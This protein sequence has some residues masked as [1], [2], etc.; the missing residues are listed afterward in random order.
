ML[1]IT[2]TPTKHHPLQPKGRAPIYTA[3]NAFSRIDVYRLSARPEKGMPD[4]GFGIIIDGGAAGTAMGD[5]SM[6]VRNYLAH[7]PEYQA[8]G[9]PYV[10][11]EHA[12]ILIIGSG[13]GREVLEGLYYGASSITAVEINPIINDIVTRRMS[14]YWGGLFEQPEVRLITEDGRSFVR[15]SN[16]KYD[17][18]ISVQT[19]TD[20]A[21]ASGALTM[22]ESYM[23]TIEA[24]EDYFDH[25]TP[26]GVLLITRPVFQIP[27]LFVTA[28]EVF[29]RRGLGNP[30]NH[31]FAFEG[32]VSSFG[33][34]KFL[35]AFLFKKSPFSEAEIREMKERLGVNRSHPST[36]DLSPEIYYSPFDDPQDSSQN[37]FRAQLTE[38]ATAPHY[39]EIC[40]ASS[41]LLSPATDDC[42]FFNQNVRLSSL[43]PWVFH[44]VLAAG[45]RGNVDSQPVAETMIVVLLF[46]AI[47]IAAVLILLPLERFSMQGLRM[48]GR[49][50]FL[51]YFAA[52]G[53]GFIMIEIVLLQRF[54]LFLGQPIYTFAVVLASLLIFTGAGSYAASLFREST[55][56]VLLGIHLTIL[57]AIGAALLLTPWVLYSTLGLSLP[58]RVAIAAAL[59][60]PLGVI[61]GMPFP[62]GL[63]IVASEASPLVPW[64][65]GVN[66]FFTVIGSI[67]AMILGMALGFTAVLMLAG[68]CYL[69]AL[70][71]ITAY[72]A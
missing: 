71:A 52:V 51:T 14:Q 10:G 55:R 44:N 61:L 27:K 7:C 34:R 29:D 17:A 54:I 22:S 67:I 39:R 28:R 36:G 6:G 69:G 65:W 31:L 19:M 60:A 59:V 18:I 1:P 8:S 47:G 56:R 16:E 2:V 57:I 5:L 13:A 4:P 25:L 70:V 50:A 11:K 66:G 72:R 24:F 3:W 58:W 23:L 12:R 20:T 62:T 41:M 63:R 9:I 53:L 68:A 42:P 38:L 15:R 64:A 49:W 46:Q 32:P 30:A 48:P 45:A 33:H 40:E 43:R 35:S 21:L 26:D 37:S